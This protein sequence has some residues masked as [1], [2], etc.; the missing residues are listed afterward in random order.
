[1]KL[2]NKISLNIAT[3]YL[4]SL[5]WQAMNWY[6]EWRMMD[7]TNYTEASRCA[8]YTRFSVGSE[9]VNYRIL[10]QR[11]LQ[12]Q[13]IGLVLCFSVSYHLSIYLSVCPILC[14]GMY[15]CV[16]WVCLHSWKYVCARLCVLECMYYKAGC[17]PACACVHVCVRTPP[18]T[19][20]Q[21]CVVCI[22][23]WD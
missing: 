22:H 7:L 12:K 19:I 14:R 10:R 17:A 5:M 6:I 18:R 1:M 3:R 16:F 15:A 23:T 21:Q 9:S 20:D 8:K 13:H 2:F 11:I 4:I